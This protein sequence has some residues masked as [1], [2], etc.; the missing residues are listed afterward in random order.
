[1]EVGQLKEF[2]MTGRLEDVKSS[3]YQIIEMCDG[4]WSLAGACDER[5]IGRCQIVE[6]A[7]H[8]SQTVTVV[9]KFR[10]MNE[11]FPHSLFFLY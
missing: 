2:V 9:V 10:K 4:C 8:C 7:D 6:V 5:K 3:K 11:G 1:M